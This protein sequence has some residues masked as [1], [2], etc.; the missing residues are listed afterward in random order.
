MWRVEEKMCKQS[1]SL[2]NFSFHFSVLFPDR[3]WDRGHDIINHI[4]PFEHQVFIATHQDL[5]LL[6]WESVTSAS[7]MTQCKHQSSVLKFPSQTNLRLLRIHQQPQTHYNAQC[8]YLRQDET[9][10]LFFKIKEKSSS[11]R[12]L[13]FKKFCLQTG[14]LHS[15]NV[16]FES[17]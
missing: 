4:I 14:A 11:F 5:C 15:N 12:I 8:S 2:F 1:S 9:S 10:L 13:Y 7:L 6:R 17:S 3:G 16:N